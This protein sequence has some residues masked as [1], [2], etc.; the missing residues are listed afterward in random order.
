MTEH[1][2][3]AKISQNVAAFTARSTVITAPIAISIIAAPLSSTKGQN[4]PKFNLKLSC[5]YFSQA[6]RAG[7][8]DSVAPAFVWKMRDAHSVRASATRGGRESAQRRV[9]VHNSTRQ[10]SLR[11]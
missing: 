2:K 1:S 7:F 5:I 4:E 6:A 8:R 3:R 10:Y 9:P 11:A